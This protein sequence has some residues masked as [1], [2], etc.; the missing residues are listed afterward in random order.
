MIFFDKF[1]SDFFQLLYKFKK[2]RLHYMGIGEVALALIR[3]KILIRFEIG[4]KL[5]FDNQVHQF[6]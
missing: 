3:I 5:L 1:H 6:V 4:V 2:V